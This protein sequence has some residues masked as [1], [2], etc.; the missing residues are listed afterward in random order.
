MSQNQEILLEARH[1]CETFRGFTDGVRV[2]FLIHRSK[3]GSKSAN[4][5]KLKKVIVR[6]EKEFE[7]ELY[8]LLVEK[9]GSELPLRIYS[10]VNPRNM[11]SA[12]RKFKED[13]LN[14]DYYDELNHHSFYLDIRNRFISALMKPSSSD[15]SY[16]IIDI[17][18]KEDCPNGL[19]SVLMAI[20]N[21]GIDSKRITQYPTKNGWHIVMHPFN[22][23]LLGVHEEKIEKDALLLLSY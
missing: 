8:N 4:N 22:P 9:H 21:A 3:E 17:D 10:C 2:L 5:D 23:K 14:A 16:F 6:N 7:T 12:I 20:A 1:I 11:A 13:Q 19:D 15:R 18:T